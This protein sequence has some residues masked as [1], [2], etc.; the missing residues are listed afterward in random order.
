MNITKN[1]MNMS[2]ILPTVSSPIRNHTGGQ[3]YRGDH[4]QHRRVRHESRPDQL[5]KILMSVA[6]ISGVAMRTPSTQP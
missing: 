1:G 5:G 6:A 3:R 4:H 2:A